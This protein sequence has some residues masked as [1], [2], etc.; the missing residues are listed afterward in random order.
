[1]HFVFA[2]RVEEVLAEMLP[3][4]MEH[5]QRQESDQLIDIVA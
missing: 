4:L 5:R 1:M 2:E 3:G